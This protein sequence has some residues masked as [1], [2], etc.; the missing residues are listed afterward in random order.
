M[1][2][3]LAGLAASRRSDEDIDRLDEA[4]R[5]MSD[6]ADSVEL[7]DGAR[8]LVCAIADAAGNAPLAGGLTLLQRSA[9]EALSLA[10]GVGRTTETTDLVNRYAR[11]ADAIEQGDAE[12][13]SR[14]AAEVVDCLRAAARVAPR[15]TVNQP[16]ASRQ[17]AHRR[18]D[19]P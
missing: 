9:G 4:L 19:R 8:R 10:H 3:A 18:G 12:R 5:T 13:A 6:A 14:A 2:S 16:P 11:L 1:V 7:A 17:A 15:S